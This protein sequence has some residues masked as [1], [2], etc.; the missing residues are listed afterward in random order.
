MN[1]LSP[2][3]INSPSPLRER[4]GVRVKSCGLTTLVTPERRPQPYPPPEGEVTIK[5]P[6][7]LPPGPFNSPSP[8]RER[9]G[10]RVKSCG[11]TTLGTPGRRPHPYP[12]PEREKELSNRPCSL[13]PGP[14][15]SPSPLRERIGVRVKSCG[16]TTLVTPE[17]RPQPY[18][19]PEGEVT[20]KRPC[21]LPP[22]L[23]HLVCRAPRH[24]RETRPRLDRGAGIQGS[25]PSDC[26]WP[27]RRVDLNRQPSGSFF[28][29]WIPAFAG[30]T[31]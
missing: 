13:S 4:I 18:P 29:H 25:R 20:I 17:R 8:L 22:G 31:G 14:I 9:V 15:N 10:V 24:S 23:S 28:G 26:P 3:P 5:R 30:M 19:P 11:Y 12:P 7:S 2:G 27:P 6:C 16:L 21:S 1:S